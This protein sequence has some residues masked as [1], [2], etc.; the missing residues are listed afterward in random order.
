METAFALITVAVA[1]IAGALAHI[2]ASAVPPVREA[3]TSPLDSAERILAM[4]YARGRISL[5]EYE[6]MTAILRR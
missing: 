4:R 6:R 5:E 1:V 2:R 3:P